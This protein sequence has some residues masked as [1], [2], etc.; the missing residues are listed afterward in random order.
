ML[1]E[2]NELTKHKTPQKQKKKKKIQKKKDARK[3]A[4]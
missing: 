2:R 1:V 3:P 4:G